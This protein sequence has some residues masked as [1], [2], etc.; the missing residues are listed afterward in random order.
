MREHGN[1]VLRDAKCVNPKMV[2]ISQTFPT[3]LN[4]CKGAD[5]CQ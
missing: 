5:V 1:K 3:K 2:E 4:T